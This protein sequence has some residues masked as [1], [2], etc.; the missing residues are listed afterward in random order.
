MSPTTAAIVGFVVLFLVMAAGMPIGFAMGLVGFTGLCYVA[1]PHVALVILAREFWDLWGS[2]ALT[3]I[4]MFMLMGALASSSGIGTRLFVV[5]NAFFGHVRGGLAIATIAACA[6]FA[7]ICGSTTAG[8]ASMGKVALPEMKR[9]HYHPSLATGTVAAGGALAVLIPPSS[10]FIIY[11]IITGESIGKLF[12]AGVIPGIILSCLYMITVY[13]LCTRD[14]KLGPPTQSVRWKGRLRALPKAIEVPLLFALVMG[15]LLSGFFSPTEAGAV[16][17]GGVLIAIIAR[18][19]FTTHAFKAAVIDTVSTTCMVLVIVAG[20]MVFGRFIAMSRVSFELID[21]VN[22]LHLHPD[23]VMAL[24]VLLYLVGG[25][26]METISLIVLTLPVLFPIVVAIGFDP[27]WFGVFTVVLGEAAVIT[28]PVGINVFV[29]KGVAPDVH[30]YTI[31]RG[32]VP[33]LY[34]IMLCLIIIFVFPQ[35]VTYLPNL[36]Y[37]F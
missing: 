12:I 19:L 13:I 25:C 29:V 34:A 9:Y 24:I 15:G 4:P 36:M 30:M 16:G 20:A 10:G 11:G 26:L 27:I 18:R 7:A 31:F 33:F 23:I 37:K 8:A 14:P 35:V 32:I 5:G 1:S 21:W 6:G 28:P 2:Y 3:V 22:R 17:A